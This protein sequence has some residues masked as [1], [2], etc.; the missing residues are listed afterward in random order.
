MKKILIIFV[1]VI[2]NMACEKKQECTCTIGKDG[3]AN[4]YEQI[5]TISNKGSNSVSSCKELESNLAN[6][7]S[8]NFV[9]CNKSY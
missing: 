3:N 7:P 1:L 4:A 8:T 6:S 5:Y 2:L 9:I